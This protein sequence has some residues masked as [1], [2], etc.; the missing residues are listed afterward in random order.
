M[1]VSFLLYVCLRGRAAGQLQRS[2]GKSPVMR[3]KVELKC[4]AMPGQ[5]SGDAGAAGRRATPTPEDGSGCAGTS[6]A[7]EGWLS[8]RLHHSAR[9][10]PFSTTQ[11]QLIGT[12]S[13]DK[14]T[15]LDFGELNGAARTCL[16][17][18]LG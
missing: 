4:W 2:R 1:C 13:S 12:L 5:Y 6:A 11:H 10:A 9:R 16:S 3:Q 17:P 15:S 7:A 8:A 18:Q 14:R